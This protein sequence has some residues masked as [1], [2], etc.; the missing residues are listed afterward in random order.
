MSN[1]K[2]LLEN[3][4][5]EGYYGKDEFKSLEDTVSRWQNKGDKMYDEDVHAF[6]KL[7][8]IL[9]YKEY[10]RSREDGRNSP[11]E[12]D[13]LMAD[14]EAG[15]N[16]KKPAHVLI[17]KQGGT[18]VGEGNHRLAIAKQLGIQEIPVQFHFVWD[19]VVK[20]KVP[21]LYRE[22]IGRKYYHITPAKNVSKILKNG[23]DPKKPQDYDDEEG[24]YLFKSKDDV[25][26]ALMNWLGDRFDEDEDLAL[27]E[28]DGN[29]VKRVSPGGAGYE[30]IVKHAIPAEAIK[31]SRSLLENKEI[32]PEDYRIAHHAPGKNS[33]DKWR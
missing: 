31:L 32:D 13:K 11:E 23:L 24:V 7:E 9:P 19:K 3:L 28:I 15:W 1:L 5:T 18:K 22:S 8:D 12:W 21:E 6:V 2:R 20:D 14:M 17:G 33:M 16:P 27:L 26:D 25:D 29:Y 4:L 30:V 10:E